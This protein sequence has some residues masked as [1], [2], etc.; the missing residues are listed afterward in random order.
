[1][2]LVGF[3]ILIFKFLFEFSHPLLLYYY[4]TASDSG[5]SA[6]LCCFKLRALIFALS[7]PHTALSPPQTANTAKNHM[8]TLIRTLVP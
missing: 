6:R 2:S 5:S 8:Y 3:D 7:P 4:D 1:M